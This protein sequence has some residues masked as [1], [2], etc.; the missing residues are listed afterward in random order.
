MRYNGQRAVRVDVYRTSDEQVLE[1]A[2]VVKDY[3]AAEVQ[4]ALPKG[5]SVEIWK[6]DSEE[7]GGRLGLMIE[8]ALLGMMLVF[9]VL[10]LF[11]EIGLAVWV[12]V[13]VGISFMGTFLVMGF[14]GVS[15]N[16]FSL[17]A[18]VLALGIVVDDAIVVGESVFAE[19]ERG[20]R[21]FAAAIRGTKRVS[22][23]VIFSVL[24]TVT[25]FA[26]LLSAPGPRGNSGGPFLSW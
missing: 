8:N 25:A 10:A 2:E 5:V 19:R 15:I 18:L 13:G 3:L 4:P 22:T 11:L 7:V 6:D 16:M 9:L 12:A 14:L 23:P 1:I 24:T 20:I 26:A 17:M 21:G